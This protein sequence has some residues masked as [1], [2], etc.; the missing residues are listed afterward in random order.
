MSHSYNKLK[1]AR[2]ESRPKKGHQRG[3][4]YHK[5]RLTFAEK[6]KLAYQKMFKNSSTERR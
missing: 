3:P 5:F 2:R 4:G 6:L 1:K